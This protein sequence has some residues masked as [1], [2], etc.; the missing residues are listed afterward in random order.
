MTSLIRQ[1]SQ[2]G[3]HRMRTLAA[4]IRMMH[5]DGHQRA[6]ATNC[7]I[8][9]AIIDQPTTWRENWPACGRFLIVLP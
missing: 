7:A 3:A 2:G 8:M 6:S 9:L 1:C 5:Q 4:P